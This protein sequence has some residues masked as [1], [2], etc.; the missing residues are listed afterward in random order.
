MA[1]GSRREFRGGGVAWSTRKVASVEETV[2]KGATG[3]EHAWDGRV[4]LRHASRDG[5]PLFFT[6]WIS[7]D[8]A[9]SA[10]DL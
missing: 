7:R 1:R 9:S 3:L 2:Q 10:R 5:G 6:P 8:V 4:G